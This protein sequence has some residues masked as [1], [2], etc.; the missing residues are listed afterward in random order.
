MTLKE[1]PWCPVCNRAVKLYPD[2]RIARHGFWMDGEGSTMCAGGGRV[3]KPGPP[4]GTVKTI[5]ACPVCGDLVALTKQGRIRAHGKPTPY[6]CR[7]WGEL[8]RREHVPSI[9]KEEPT[10]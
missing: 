2:G 4:P 6:R 9:L 5:G 7:G 1:P 8:V 10:E 3:Y